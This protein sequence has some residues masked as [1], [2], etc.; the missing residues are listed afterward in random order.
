M[1]SIKT[2]KVKDGSLVWHVRYT[3]Q[4]CERTRSI[5]RVRREDAKR[6]Q[7]RVDQCLLEGK[8]P[9]QTS[10]LRLAKQ[11]PDPVEQPQIVTLQDA[12]AMYDK[13]VSVNGRNKP[14]TLKSKRRCFGT[15]PNRLLSKPLIEIG[16]FDLENWL[17]EYGQTRDTGTVSMANAYMTTVFNWCIDFDMLTKSPM[18]SIKKSPVEQQAIKTLTETQAVELLKIAEGNFYRAVFIALNFGLRS[19]EIIRLTWDDVVEE[20]GSIRVAARGNKTRTGRAVP[21]PSPE[22]MDKILSWKSSDSLPTDQVV[23]YSTTYYIS[24]RFREIRRAKGWPDGLTFHSTRHTYITRLQT[25]GVQIAMVARLAG[26]SS[27][28]VTEKYY[29]HFAPDD[30]KQAASRLNYRSGGKPGESRQEISLT[31][32]A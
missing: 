26:H 22:V 5:G 6:E 1:S 23:P 14:S 20:D 27:V 9:D 12:L 8:D 2:K 16:K 7:N 32:A 21:A 31:G 10:P 4:G 24:R 3:Y 28:H 13:Y 17:I 25:S 11:K 15:V 30:L 29:T 19:G 18:K